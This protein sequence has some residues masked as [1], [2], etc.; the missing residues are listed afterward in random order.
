LHNPS[1]QTPV[2]VSV[3]PIIKATGVSRNLSF[4]SFPADFSPPILGLEGESFDTPFSPE[5]VKWKDR[6]LTLEEFPTPGYITP[7]PIKVATTIEEETSIPSRPFS[8][9]PRNTVPVS[10]VRSPSPPGS[11]PVHIPMAGA[12]LP[13]SRM[14]SIVASRYAPLV[15][16]QPLS[17]LP[18][19]GY[20]K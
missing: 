9:S 3:Y 18:A 8:L 2:T 16:P 5:V 20:L 15:L 12:N 17:A 4:G 19:D 11:P 13:R 14:D 7:P 1:L 10:P 6:A